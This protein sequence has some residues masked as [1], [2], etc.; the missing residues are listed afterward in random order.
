MKLKLL[1]PMLLLG[2]GAFAQTIALQQFASGFSAI[3]EIAHAGTN[4]MYVVEK[5]G[6]IKILEANGTIS[7]TPFLNIS[8]IISTTG[9][10]GLLGLA[11]HPQYATNGY[12]YVYYTNTAGNIVVARYSRN[13]TNPDVADAASGLVLLTIPHPVNS[14]HNGGCIHFG[15][16]GYLY[17]STGD[18]GGGGDP[19]GN[20]QN[21]AVLLGKMLRIDINIGSSTD[22]NYFIPPTNPFIIAGGSQEIW[23]Y[24]LR[25]AWK[26]SFNRLNGDMWIADVGQGVIEEINK[27]SA[28]STGLNFGWRCYEGNAPFNT[29]PSS[30]CPAI[31]TLTFPVAQ[32]D[33]TNNACSITGGYVYT[34]ATYTNLQ[35]KYLFADY[36]NNRIG[37]VNSTTPGTITWTESFSGNFTT[38]AENADGE[39]FIAGGSN[40]IV[41]RI[42]DATAGATPFSKAGITLYPN[43]ANKEVFVSLKNTAQTATAT[44]YDLNGKRL[45]QQHLTLQDNRIDT[46]ALQAGIYMLEVNTGESRMQQKLV[47]N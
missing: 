9:E 5:G 33:H 36:C 42:T 2:T 46:S 1:L 45:I 4:R 41:Y 14:N 22:T 10:R 21:T 43:P 12:F 32:Y 31:S 24:G 6:R 38:F 3:T 13:T 15:P 7:A 11:F 19:N 20:A 30:N 29:Q 35:N 8:S 18:G 37:W 28:T 34:G 16:D 26:F 25:N 39:L 27:V 40:G 47:I 44:L 17:I 23:G